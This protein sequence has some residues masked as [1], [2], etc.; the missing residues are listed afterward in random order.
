M[1]RSSSLGSHRHRRSDLL[2]R[3]PPRWRSATGRSSRRSLASTR[4]V[5]RRGGTRAL[6]DTVRAEQRTAPERLF[7]RVVDRGRGDDRVEHAAGLGSLG[8][9]DGLRC[10]SADGTL[11]QVGKSAEARRDLL[12]RFR[13][14]ARRWPRCRSSSIALT[15]GWLATQSATAADSPADAR[16]SAGSSAP[17]APT[18][19]CTLRTARRRDRRTDDAVQRDARSDRRA[20]DRRCAARSTTCPM[21]SGRR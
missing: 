17:A 20:R 9:G 7:V 6:A 15:G 3:P 11:V 1:P 12:A 14:G 5:Y 2:L 18:S 16:R 19:A 10:S 8:A 4:G 21:I 13:A